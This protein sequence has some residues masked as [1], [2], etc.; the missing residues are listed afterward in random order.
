MS[1]QELTA[2]KMAAAD[3]DAVALAA[4]ADALEE[5]GNPVMAAIH[6]AY[7]TNHDTRR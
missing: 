4:Y 5:S 1:E 3:G 2:L 6:R 7:L